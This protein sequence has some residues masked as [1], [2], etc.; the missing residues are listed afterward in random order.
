MVSIGEVVLEL[1]ADGFTNSDEITAGRV[2][3]NIDTGTF[4]CQVEAT[5]TGVTRPKGPYS[6]QEEARKALIEFWAACDTALGKGALWT[7]LE[8]V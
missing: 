5:I 8:F 2:L 4:T 1:R 6:T 3:K 7:P